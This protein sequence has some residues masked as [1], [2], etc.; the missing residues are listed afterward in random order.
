MPRRVFAPARNLYLSAQY[1]A[2]IDHAGHRGLLEDLA[3][4]LDNGDLV[5]VYA[6]KA[7]VGRQKRCVATCRRNADLPALEI[8]RCLNGSLFKR[9]DPQR[10][11]VTLGG[12]K[13]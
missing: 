7:A 4:E 6:H 5:E 13:P 11:V 8:F 9:E 3:V 12:K 10:R 2:R 1:R